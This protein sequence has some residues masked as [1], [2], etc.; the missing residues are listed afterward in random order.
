[1]EL[2]IIL[3]ADF[4]SLQISVV[5]S[6]FIDQRTSTEKD[7]SSADPLVW[8][9]AEVGK[10]VAAAPP[11]LSIV[12]NA[13]DVA[14]KKEAASPEKKGTSPSCTSTYSGQCLCSLKS[15]AYQILNSQL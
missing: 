11:P 10:E 14:D 12:R 1:M 3:W 15:L 8:S 6:Q 4:F 9:V 13:E 7:V 2:W 5:N